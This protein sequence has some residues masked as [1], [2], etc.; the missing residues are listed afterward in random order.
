MYDDYNER[1]LVRMTIGVG[2]GVGS[3]AALLLD[4]VNNVESLII[5]ILLSLIVFI[6]GYLAHIAYFDKKNLD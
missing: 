4:H 6:H 1:G 5:M 3:L 2:F